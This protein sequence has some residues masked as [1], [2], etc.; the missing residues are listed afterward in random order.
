MHNVQGS[1]RKEHRDGFKDIE[2]RFMERK[3]ILVR[4]FPGRKFNET[5]EDA[6]LLCG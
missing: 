1:E 6:D 2:I 3:R 4:L 5:E